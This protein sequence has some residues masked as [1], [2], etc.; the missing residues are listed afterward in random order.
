MYAVFSPLVQTGTCAKAHVDTKHNRATGKST[1]LS[2]LAVFRQ[3]Q[4]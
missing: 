3:A 2:V 1:A 4:A